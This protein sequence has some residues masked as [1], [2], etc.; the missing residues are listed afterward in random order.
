M[1][2]LQQIYAAASETPDRLAVVFNGR[3]VTYGEFWRLIDGRRRSLDPFLPES[4]V[5][6]VAIDDIL[7]S[8]LVVLALRG[9]GV[10]T[11]V[12]RNAEEA[13]LFDG[14]D[15]ACLITLD[16]DPRPEIRAPAGARRLRLADPAGQLV[17]TAE[18]LPLQ[19]NLRAPG[20]HILLTSGTTGRS[21]MVRSM[22]GDTPD[23]IESRR[24]RYVE[25]EGHRPTGAD[26]VS[27]IF[28]FGLWTAAGHSQP[29]FV[30]CQK[31]AVVIHQGEDWHK[32]L[33]WPGL[34]HATVT[35]HNLTELM[36]L[37][38]DA[39]PAHPD[40]QLSITAGAVTP[41]LIRETRR[42]LTSRI[43]ITLASTE[44]G[45]WARTVVESDEDLRWYRLDPKRRVEV[46]DDAGRPLPPGQLGRVRV[47]LRPN[48]PRGYH[49]DAA[50]TAAFFDETWFYPGDLGVLDGKG[51]LALHGRTT[52][53]VHI[54]GDKYPAEPWERAIQE[55]V[56]C[57]AV[58]V[59]SGRW[60]SHEERLHVFIESR[61][62]IGAEA[63]GEALRTTLFGFAD[64]QVHRV[65]AMPRTGAGKIKRRALAQQLHD[66]AVET[67]SAAS[68]TTVPVA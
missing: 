26:T 1:Y 31:G 68:S 45:G 19:P 54:N 66:Q 48:D 50:T 52:D 44:A 49:G 46:V 42:R 30:W 25:L 53:I 28:N 6:I 65:Q 59:I 13:A 36:A 55:K 62:P 34:T 4:G 47:A 18:P 35:P 11:A 5:A 15:V 21:K 9:L 27:A 37:P 3:A 17:S 33:H 22:R 61:R 12:V 38:Q 8:W 67:A 56:E 60:G 24:Q 29:I 39:Y 16:A 20:G 43:T 14:L 58:C 40:M 2:V 51:R 32:A 63:L 10:D 23:A 57:D 7:E 41:A 64:V